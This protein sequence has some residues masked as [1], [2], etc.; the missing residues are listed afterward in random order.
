MHS[1]FSSPSQF[2][3]CEGGGCATDRVELHIWLG[4]CGWPLT[5]RPFEVPH[6][7]GR[8]LTD[9]QPP[10][11]TSTIIARFLNFLTT[12]QQHIT[13]STTLPPSLTTS[14]RGTMKLLSCFRRPLQDPEQPLL[15]D[16]YKAN[17]VFCTVS[18]ENG[19]A[20]EYEVN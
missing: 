14:A 7:H 12:A 3:T 19:F 1:S 16:G 17:C 11:P 2:D 13:H 9:L 8:V 4:L 10:L 15:S 18:T 20:V 5:R 6:S